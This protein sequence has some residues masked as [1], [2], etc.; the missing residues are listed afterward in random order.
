MMSR[1][2]TDRPPTHPGEML[3]AEFFEPLGLT[4]ETVAVAI[5]YSSSE[6]A[7]VVGGEYPMSA[8]LAV[9]L[10]RYLGMGAEF[11]MTLQQAWDIWHAQQRLGGTAGLLRRIVPLAR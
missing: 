10:D 1:L 2:P 11:W 5:D 4:V 9:R 7:A 6:L 8:E 3:R